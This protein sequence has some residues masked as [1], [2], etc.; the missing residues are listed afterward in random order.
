MVLNNID[1]SSE[2]LKKLMDEISA[3]CQHQWPN[4]SSEKLEVGESY[5]YFVPQFCY[6][7]ELDD[8]NVLFFFSLYR[9][10]CSTSVLV[11]MASRTIYKYGEKYIYLFFLLEI[12]IHLEV[13]VRS[14]NVM[15]I[16]TKLHVLLDGC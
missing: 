14:S 5:F 11:V 12:S 4:D 7:N 16:Y 9:V 2:Y 3:F 6:N 15:N 13:E 10:A 8:H 1:V